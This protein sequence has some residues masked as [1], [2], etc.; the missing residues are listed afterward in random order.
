MDHWN[1][2]IAVGIGLL[3]GLERERRKGSGPEREAAGIR[4]FA[5]VALLGGISAEFGGIG[6]AAAAVFVGGA[7][8]IAYA[9]RRHDD[10]GLTTEITLVVTFLLGALTKSDAA[11]AATIAVIVTALLASR[12]HIHRFVRD[13]L[14]PQE[15]HDALVLCASAIVILPLVPDHAIGPYEAF[16]PFVIWRTVVIVMTISALGYVALRV[17]GP[18]LGLP[19]TGL[20]GGLVSS[21]ATMGAMGGQVRR[22]PQTMRPG[23]AGAILATSMSIVELA[24]IVGSASRA[25][26]SALALP[27]ALSGG[28]AVV[29]SVA[30]VTRSLSSTTAN[31]APPGRA[32][33]LKVAVTFALTVAVL[34][35]TAGVLRHWL[36]LPGL[37]LGVGLAGLA[38]LHAGAMSVIGLEVSG[39]VSPDTAAIAVVIAV[40][41]NTVT[42]A[43][44]AVVAGGPAFAVRVIPGLIAVAAATWA[45]L[46][47]STI[48]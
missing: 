31:G 8:L 35:F 14:S 27:L 44:L 45:G 34:T 41:A 17:V 36:G 22:D 9:T 3:V 4:T 37:Y 33:D 15:V 16:N 13:V 29:F 19:L 7:S 23:A 20:L 12:D 21:T 42:K 6:I 47:L 11:L 5:L 1:L 26:L 40:S 46:A 10:P 30:L 32:F 28:A 24:V 2:V 38:D 39:Q 43:A 18:R 48:I 25:T